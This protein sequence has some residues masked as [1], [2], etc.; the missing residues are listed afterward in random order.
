MSAE[1]CGDSVGRA[2]CVRRI[3]CWR[4]VYIVSGMRQVRAI[5]GG[6]RC[7]GSMVDGARISSAECGKSG[8]SSTDYSAAG[9]SLTE[10]A[11]RGGAIIGGA[12]NIA[13]NSN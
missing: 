12:P 2:G 1:R 9:L 6:V 7:G 11:E 5:T 10:Q 8:L 13:T 3:D 4:G